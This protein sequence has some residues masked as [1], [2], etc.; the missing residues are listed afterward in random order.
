V[1]AVSASVVEGGVGAVTVHNADVR[2]VLVGVAVGEPT[3]VGVGRG[4]G[5]VAGVAVG[6]GVLVGIGI[7]VLVG[8]DVGV[9]VRVDVTVGMGVL[10]GVFVGV[11]VGVGV[12]V[13]LAD[14]TACGRTFTCAASGSN[15]D[16]RRCRRCLRGRELRPPSVESGSSRC[17]GVRRRGP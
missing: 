14:R 1:K 15:R 13:F 17:C 12:L 8:V 9:G 3:G 7:G 6:V 5:D 16:R 2:G 4:V 10:V 11:D